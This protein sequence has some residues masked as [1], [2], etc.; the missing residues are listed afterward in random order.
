MKCDVVFAPRGK[1]GKPE[2]PK[3]A[4]AKK[5][6]K[7]ARWNNLE[8]CLRTTQQ[9]PFE[10]N[11]PVEP[12]VPNPEPVAPMDS[13]EL[14]TPWG[15]K[16][17]HS[18]LSAGAFGNNTGRPVEVSRRNMRNLRPQPVR[19]QSAKARAG[20]SSRV[21]ASPSS[22]RRKNEQMKPAVPTQGRPTGSPRRGS[23]GVRAARSARQRPQS[24]GATRPRF[25]NAF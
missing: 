14:D 20:T 21:G 13:V 3:S 9:L 10:V 4:P 1:D 17:V 5:T 19:P 7:N 6:H 22:E 8:R 25:N 2:R 24:A 16:W 11:Y 12:V 18:R 15:G 23:A